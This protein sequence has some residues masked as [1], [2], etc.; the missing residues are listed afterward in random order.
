MSPTAEAVSHVRHAP[1]PAAIVEALC[2]RYRELDE[3]I[4]AILKRAKEDAKPHADEL[5]KVEEK[6]RQYT[7]E[8]GSAHADKSQL[9]SGLTFESMLT[10][11]STTTI[12]N[13]GVLRFEQWAEKDKKR[14]P[15]FESLFNAIKRW[16]LTPNAT[17]VIQAKGMPAVAKRLFAACLNTKPNTPRLTVREKKQNAARD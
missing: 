15:I 3:K 16:E 5:A 9:L 10:R 13:A 2:L 4:T 1:P 6:L 17:A 8:F 12:E 14:K 11:S 7:A